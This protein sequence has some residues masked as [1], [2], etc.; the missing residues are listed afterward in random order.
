MTFNLDAEAVTRA[1]RDAE[2]VAADL[3]RAGAVIS[4]GPT[5][6]PDDE[7]CAR[8]QRRVHRIASR[9]GAN[10]RTLQDLVREADAVDGQVSLSFLLLLGRWR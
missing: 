3:R 4:F 8:L 9:T 6:V 1:G 7:A 5:A 2:R 10:G